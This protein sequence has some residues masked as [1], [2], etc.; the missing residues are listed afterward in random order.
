MSKTISVIH[1]HLGKG[2]KGGCFFIGGIPGV[3][4][5]II[6][7]ILVPIYA[8]NYFNDGVLIKLCFCV[9]IAWPFGAFIGLIIGTLV[10]LAFF[11][12]F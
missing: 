10:Y 5:E 1:Y 2:G 11:K 9:F 7:S 4:G 8:W 3:I 12:R 6:G